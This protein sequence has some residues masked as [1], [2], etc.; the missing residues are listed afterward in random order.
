MDSPPA[1][2]S[3]D[4]HLRFTLAAATGEIWEADITTGRVTL[5]AQFKERLGYSAGEIA[6]TAESWYELTHPDDQDLLC[7]AWIDHLKLRLPYDI[8]YRARTKSGEYRWFN[9]KG[10]AVWDESGRA[11]Y[12]AG[13]VHDI[14]S[15]REAQAQAQEGFERF[16]K[17]FHLSPIATSLTNLEDAS[18]LDVN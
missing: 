18:I 10:Q 1:Q 6:D 12:M 5:S 14:T 4:S 15:T 8:Q 13:V 7:K 11:T 17:F 9:S 16:R 2:Q 3:Q